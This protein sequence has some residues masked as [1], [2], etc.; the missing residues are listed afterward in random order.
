M[1]CLWG[2]ERILVADKLFHLTALSLCF[3][4]LRMH[5]DRVD[6]LAWCCPGTSTASGVGRAAHELSSATC[7]CC[8]L[9]SALRVF[10]SVCLAGPG[11]LY[12]CCCFAAP[13]RAA[14]ALVASR[15]AVLVPH[16]RTL[17][18]HIPQRFPLLGSLSQIPVSPLSS[19]SHI[20]FISLSRIQLLL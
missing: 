4:V 13:L 17:L 3:H 14:L 16:K 19:C 20:G 8:R 12:S 9:N 11:C 2:K 5:V 15:H 6:S 1:R 10:L 7:S 18:V